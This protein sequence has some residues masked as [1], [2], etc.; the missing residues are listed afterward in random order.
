[1]I[2]DKFENNIIP[3]I[4]I[5]MGLISNISIFNAFIA[6]IGLTIN[7]ALLE[8]TL[9]EG[10]PVIMNKNKRRLLLIIG[11]I[12]TIASLINEI[13]LIGIIIFG[14]GLNWIVFVLEQAIEKY[15]ERSK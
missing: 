4:L 8:L 5:F 12:I 6:L 3:L 2:G 13:S 7:V 9:L 11:N 1:M 14:I 10:V 15:V